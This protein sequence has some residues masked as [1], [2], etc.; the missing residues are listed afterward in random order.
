M[1]EIIITILYA[2]MY[3][4]HTRMYSENVNLFEMLSIN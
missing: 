1:M 2:I 4:Y 3:L